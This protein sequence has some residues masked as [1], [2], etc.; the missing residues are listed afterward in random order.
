MSLRALSLAAFLAAF[1]TFILLPAH[2]D[3]RKLFPAEAAIP[4]SRIIHFTSA[5]DK[6]PYTI[7]ISIPFKPAPKSGYPVMYV[8][9]GELYFPEAAVAANWLGDKGAVVVGIGHDALNDKTVIARYARRNPENGKPLDGLAAINAFQTMRNYDFGW[10][11]KSEHRAP[12]FVE[13]DI[14]PETGD[15]DAFLQVIE[16]EIKPKVEAL[17]PVDR[18]NQALFGH[19]LGGLA[20]VRALFTEPTAFRTFIPASP[21]LWYDGGTVLASEKQF[22]EAVT[23]R[24]IAPRVLVTVGARE[25]DNLAPTKDDLV[26]FTPAQRAEIAPYGTMLGTWPGMITGARELAARLKALHGKPG[27]TVDYQLIADQNHPSSA[28]V[29]II[30]AIPFAFPEK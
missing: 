27:Y 13:K 26:K 17:I 30:R 22:A 21:S 18:S 23:A 19:S 3:D 15:V 11:V 10:P 24:R 25:P 1:A 14:G 12:A 28:Y 9:D 7:Q 8:L 2:A 6:E 20:V 4:N 16:K 5:I 29:A